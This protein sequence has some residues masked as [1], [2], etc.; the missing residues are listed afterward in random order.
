MTTLVYA[1]AILLAIGGLIGYLKAGSMPS[2]IMGLLSGLLVG[3]SA[4][5]TATNKKNGTQ[6]TMAL[7]LVLLVIMGMRFV[8]SGKFFPAGLVSIFS[9]VILVK[10]FFFISF[11]NVIEFSHTPK[12]KKKNLKIRKREEHNELKRKQGIEIDDND[13]NFKI[14]R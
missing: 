3:Y 11:P 2:L 12:Q 13:K 14:Y 10:V 4:N 6:L 8:N 7:S 5:L 9:A 1:Y